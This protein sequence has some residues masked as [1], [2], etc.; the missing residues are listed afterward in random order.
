[1]KKEEKKIPLKNYISVAI[2]FTFTILLVLIL[3]GWHKQ[4]EEYNLKTPVLDG[5]FQ[6][7]KL[8][9][10]SSYVTAHDDFYLY[11]GV[12]EDKVSRK[13]EKKLIKV[14]EN[15]EIKDNTIYINASSIEN[16]VY[17]ELTKYNYNAKNV[18]LPIFMI[19]KNKKILDYTMK[20]DNNF[21][22]GDIEKLLDEY[23]VGA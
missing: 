2:M 10:L 19:I 6:E 21:S 14:L 9:E 3:R 4:Y 1:M 13:V 22:I 11:I 20:K 16:D 17:Y 18:E 8:N 5:K 12:A 15:R 7:V 23:E